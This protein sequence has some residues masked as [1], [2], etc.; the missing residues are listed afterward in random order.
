MLLPERVCDRIVKWAEANPS[1]FVDI[2]N[3]EGGRSQADL[4]DEDSAGRVVDVLGGRPKELRVLRSSP[5]TLRQR[6][7]YDKPPSDPLLFG[8]VA[9]QPDT[10]MIVYDD[11]GRPTLVRLM[12]GEVLWLGNRP[13][14]GCS[15][16]ESRS[17]PSYRIHFSFS[18][19][20]DA[21]HLLRNEKKVD[22]RVPATAAVQ[23]KQAGV[24]YGVF[25]GEIVRLW[26]QLADGEVVRISPVSPCSLALPSHSS[27]CCVKTSDVMPIGTDED[28]RPCGFNTVQGLSVSPMFAE[29]SSN[30]CLPLH[31]MYRV[32]V[33]VKTAAGYSVRLEVFHDHTVRVGDAE[34]RERMPCTLLHQ[35]LKVS[36][37]SANY[38]LHKYDK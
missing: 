14:A 20:G 1:A 22:W 23:R 37:G 26:D 7:H 15:L 12:K 33:T 9:L 32:P 5:G 2:L 38:L 10:D 19:L 11:G 25:F 18:T 16:P 13:H 28:G 27:C 4:T 30:G 21:I 31:V 35:E 8:L 36:H 6:G 17:G 34:Q 29:V 24:W 3:P